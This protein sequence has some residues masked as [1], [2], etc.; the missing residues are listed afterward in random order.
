MGSSSSMGSSR[1]RQGGA[2]HT[3]RQQVGNQPRP[4]QA[5]AEAGTAGAGDSIGNAG[6]AGLASLAQRPLLG[7]SAGALPSARS[8][9]SA[10]GS[11]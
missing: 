10:S 2:E 7:A 11:W 4:G 3:G 8:R 5:E 6:G 1:G 9:P